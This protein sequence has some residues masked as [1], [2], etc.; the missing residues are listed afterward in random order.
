MYLTKRKRIYYNK[1]GK[2]FSIYQLILHIGKKDGLLYDKNIEIRPVIMTQK[3]YLMEVAKEESNNPTNEAK[4][5][6]NMCWSG[7]EKDVEEDKKELEQ[8]ALENVD[9][10]EVEDYEES[11]GD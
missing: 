10:L 8:K 7:T 2:Q 3:G 11:K 9:F 4:A 1:Q 6:A 5:N